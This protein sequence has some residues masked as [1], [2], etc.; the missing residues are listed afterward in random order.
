MEGRGGRGG[1]TLM[2]VFPMMALFS[3]GLV[4]D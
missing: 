2:K 3:S 4:T 1:L